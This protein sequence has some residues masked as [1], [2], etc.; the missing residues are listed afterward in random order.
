VALSRFVDGQLAWLMVVLL[1]VAVGLGALQ[2]IG[3]NAP[4]GETTG[5]PIE[6]VIPPA[7]A[8]VAGARLLPIVPIGL[9]IIP[10]VA[11]IASFADRVAATEARLARA[12]TRPSAGDRTGVR[13]QALV[14]AFG[15]FIGIAALAAGGLGINSGGIPPAQAGP[16]ERGGLAVADGVVA[17][18]LAY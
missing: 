6:S 10:G 3:A 5:I 7:L 12:S 4:S 18:L 1:L 9:L 11:G 16:F 14:A 8:A 2:V 17:F 13:V 15:G